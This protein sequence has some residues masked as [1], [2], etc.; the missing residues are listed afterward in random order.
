MSDLPQ[1]PAW[2]FRKGEARIFASPDDVPEG[3]GWVDSPALVTDEPE[4]IEDA[5]KKRGRPRKVVESDDPSDEVTP[6]GDS[7]GN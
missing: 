4:I 1:W 6:D 3:E 5:P 2:R 7:D